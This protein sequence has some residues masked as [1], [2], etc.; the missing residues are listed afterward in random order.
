MN[1][2][3]NFEV[4]KSKIEF[5]V[6]TCFKENIQKY[7]SDICSFALISDDGAMTV[8]PFTNIKTHLKKM[9]AENPEQ[10]DYY[11]FEPAEW[12]TSNGANE[13]FNAICKMVS[14]EIDNEELDFE[15][16]R[17]TLFASCV[18][19]LEKLRTEGFFQKELGENL[20]VQFNISDTDESKDNLIHWT[21]RLN[22]STYAKRYQDYIAQQ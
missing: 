20:L 4:L 18:E 11:E 17:N 16:F 15:Y 1:T 21:K 8:V 10:R 3:F 5:A 22:D 2:N 6:K 12:F 19:V 7:G 14:L 9:Q 13:A